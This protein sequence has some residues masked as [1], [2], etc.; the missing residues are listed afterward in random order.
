MNVAAVN[1]ELMSGIDVIR[2]FGMDAF[3]AVKDKAK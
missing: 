3:T 1:S 2:A